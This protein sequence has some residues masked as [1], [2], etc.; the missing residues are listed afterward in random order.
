[1][2]QLLDILAEK[3]DINKGVY[4]DWQ[5]I[6][7][8]WLPYYFEKHAPFHNYHKNV[9]GEMKPRKKKTANFGKIAPRDIAQLLFNDKVEFKLPSDSDSEK[10]HD[11]LEDLDFWTFTTNNLEQSG[12]TGT[13]AVEVSIN[14]LGVSGKD[15]VNFNDSELKLTYIP[16]QCIF[17]ITWENTKLTE[18][19][20]ASSKTI[21]GVNY[22]VA[23]IHIKREG[24]YV[25]INHA[26][27]VKNNDLQDI[28]AEELEDLGIAPEINTGTDFPWFAIWK[29]SGVNNFRPTYPYGV[30]YIAHVLDSMQTL[31]TECTAKDIE[32]VANRARMFISADMCTDKN[33]KLFFDPEEDF[34]QLTKKGFDGQDLTIPV[35]SPLRTS[36]IVESMNSTLALLGMAVGLGTTHFQITPD[37][38][39]KEIGVKSTLDSKIR[40]KI[41]EETGLESFLFD[42][43]KVILHANGMSSE[44]LRVTFD[45]SMLEDKN[46]Q[47][48]LDMRKVD[49]GLMSVERFLMKW[50]G[51]DKQGA[52]EEAR[53]IQGEHEM[54]VD[55]VEFKGSD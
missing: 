23:T 35:I 17:P 54:P 29:P 13:G 16:C 38:Q 7:K 49:N 55:R 37:G 15:V 30:P 4:E 36:S 33:G 11:I 6:V 44:G 43:L 20:F 26:F 42:Q 9:N 14:N 31:D 41:R 5:G 3:Y 34:V 48:E 45:N 12:A 25:I 2:G 27:K 51:F 47:M 32:I 52:K 28:T 53:K 10:L 40:F 24:Q 39:E 19:A 21:R 50:E 22:V 8:E 1:M 46:T 18:C